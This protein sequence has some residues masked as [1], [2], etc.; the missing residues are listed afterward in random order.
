[1]AGGRVW[2]TVLTLVFGCGRRVER[3]EFW[4][5]YADAVCDRFESCPQSD[6]VGEMPSHEECVAE[7]GVTLE[8]AGHGESCYDLCF[9]DEDLGSQCIRELH[10]ID[11]DDFLRGGLPVS[12]DQAWDCADATLPGCA[13]VE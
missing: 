5:R 4:D 6:Y 8:F 10:R 1:M 7:V 2:V 11:C 9:Y 12:C 3:D 13:D